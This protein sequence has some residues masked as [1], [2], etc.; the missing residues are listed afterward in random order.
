LASFGNITPDTKALY[1]NLL[2]FMKGKDRKDEI[3][4]DITC[5]K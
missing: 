4:E 1:E 2:F 3:F 5:Y